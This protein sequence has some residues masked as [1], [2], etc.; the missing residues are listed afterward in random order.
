MQLNM[1]HLVIYVMIT[2][3]KSYYFPIIRARAWWS[4][5]FL[6]FTTMNEHIFLIWGG[7]IWKCRINTNLWPSW[8]ELFRKKKNDGFDLPGKGITLHSVALFL[9]STSPPLANFCFLLHQVKM[10]K[11]LTYS[12]LQFFLCNRGWSY[13]K[14]VF[15]EFTALP[16]QIKDWY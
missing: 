14:S 8:P 12:V 16:I 13:L 7:K 5:I 3:Q 1:F 15:N 11:Q 2:T 6:E 9:L 4:S 10:E